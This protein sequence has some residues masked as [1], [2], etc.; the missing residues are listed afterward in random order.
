MDDRARQ[1]RLESWL[2]RPVSRKEAILTVL[3]SAP[4]PMTARQVMRA[5]G[6]SDMNSVRPRMT[7]LWQEG[8]VGIAG[9]VKDDVTGKRTVLYEAVDL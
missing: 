2:D 1:T 5:L 4:A 9:K 6:Y 7:E 8:K 3:R